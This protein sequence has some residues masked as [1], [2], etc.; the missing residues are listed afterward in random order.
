MHLAEILADGAA[1]HDRAAASPRR[2]RRGSPARRRSPRRPRGARR[3]TA[4]HATS[5]APRR[6]SATSARG[7]SPSC[8]DWEQL[9][10][11]GAAIKDDV[12]ARPAG[13]PRRARGE[14]HRGGRRSSTGRAT[15]TRRTRSS[16]GIV[17]ATHGADEVVKVKSM[18]TQE[19]ELNE[20]L[21][22]RGDRR[23]GDRPRRAHRPA[24]P[25]PAVPLPR[26]RRS[27]ATGPR[28]GDIF[29]ARDGGVGRPAPEGLTDEP[30]EL[31]EAARLHL[32]EKF[33]RGAGRDLGREL[34][35]RRDRAPS[36]SSSPRATAGCA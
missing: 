35:G 5:R 20:A 27:T 12:L 8:A 31:A 1:A 2:R 33:L 28:S 26:A 14:R 6:R 16:S 32:R 17:A 7:R 30:A 9:R 11:A 23:L 18:A 3:T 21:A 10:L 15:P 36:W 22:Q 13:A 19:I 24:G 29:Q 4:A 34:R 25:R